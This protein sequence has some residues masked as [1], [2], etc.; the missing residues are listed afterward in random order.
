MWCK[1]ILTAVREIAKSF[2]G[3]RDDVPGRVPSIFAGAPC[4][5]PGCNLG[6]FFTSVNNVPRCG[7]AALNRCD[8][9]L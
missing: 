9:P 6:A 7:V 4:I 1:S 2:S 3:A 8:G 5:F